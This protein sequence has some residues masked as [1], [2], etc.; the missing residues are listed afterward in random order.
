MTATAAVAAPAD[1]IA[2]TITTSSAATV[3]AV[4]TITAVSKKAPKSLDDPDE[5]PNLF[6]DWDVSLSLEA[7]SGKN[8]CNYPP[9]ELY[10]IYAQ[11]STTNLLEK[12][13]SMQIDENDDPT[14]NGQHDHEETL[15]NEENHGQEAVVE[16]DASSTN[17]IIILDSKEDDE[18][19]GA[20]DENS[21]PQ[22]LDVKD[23]STSADELEAKDENTSPS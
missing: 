13:K 2:T 10:P 15:G 22:K 21:S 3:T 9:A 23:E 7:E 1:V 19:L 14:E 4:A 16:E 8:R 11:K 5:Y 20:K 18:E 17:G 12:F 6:D